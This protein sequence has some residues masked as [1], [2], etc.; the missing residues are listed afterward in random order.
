MDKL[1]LVCDNCG[2]KGYSGETA[3]E[4]DIKINAC[5]LPDGTDGGN[6]CEKH[7]NEKCYNR[8]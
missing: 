4:Q 1:E 2:L 7:F 6:Y 8:N 3:D 5:L